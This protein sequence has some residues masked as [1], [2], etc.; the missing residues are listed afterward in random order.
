MDLE[1]LYKCQC[2]RVYR[3]AM[4]YLKSP[5]D[6]EDAVQNVFMKLM[7][8]PMKFDNKEH[9]DAWFITVT[10]NYCKDFLKSYWKRKVAFGELPECSSGQNGSDQL[11]QEIWKLP[12]K[13][14]EVLY[15]Y[16]Y[17]EYAI[18]EISVLLHRKESTIQTQLATARKRLKTELEREG[19]RYGEE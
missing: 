4:L 11:V 5:Y 2:D 8:R 19:M 12:L 1:E 14:R 18:K 13:Y 16:Y 9:E 3:V 6:A 17:E 10:K 7:D 15:L